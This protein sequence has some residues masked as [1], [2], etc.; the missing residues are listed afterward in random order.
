MKKYILLILMAYSALILQ[1]TML[2][3]LQIGGVKP[4]LI[5]VLVICTAVIC[6]PERGLGVGLLLG[7][8]EDL[9]FGKFIGMNSLCKGLTALIAGWFTAGT[10][11]EN[12]LVPV[13]SVFLGSI[14]NGA[15]FFLVGLSM[16]MEWSVNIFFTAVLPMAFYNMCIV[17]FIYT[18]YHKFAQGLG[19]LQINF[20]L[21]KR[22]R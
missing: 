8:A 21:L 18:P 7:L 19:D 11:S 15:L 3:S 9:Y 5:L 10:F 20:D 6:G 13:L 16:G 22:D 4:D 2:N 14:V 12:L 17:P 1:S